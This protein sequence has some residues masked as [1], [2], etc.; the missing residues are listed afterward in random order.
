MQITHEE[1]HWYEEYDVDHSPYKEQHGRQDLMIL[2]ILSGDCIPGD[3]IVWG[4]VS[5]GDQRVETTCDEKGSHDQEPAGNRCL[6]VIT[7][8]MF[9][10]TKKRK[11]IKKG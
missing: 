11:K 5:R 10:T 1:K 6:S 7:E 9:E 3:A 8:S 4:A 2:G